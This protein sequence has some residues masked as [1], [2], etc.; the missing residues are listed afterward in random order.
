MDESW[1][2]IHELAMMVNLGFVF[3]YISTCQ[4][5][6]EEA[7]AESFKSMMKKD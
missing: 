4:L 6:T 1:M 3:I 5:S 2:I 7:L